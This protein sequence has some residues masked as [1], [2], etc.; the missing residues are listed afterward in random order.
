MNKETVFRIV[1]EGVARG[2]RFAAITNGHDLEHFLPVLGEDRI[3]QIQI[4]L[5]GPKRLHD[6]SRLARNPESSFYKII[7][8]I[9]L[10]PP[11]PAAPPPPPTPPRTEEAGP[12]RRGPAC[13]NALPLHNDAPN[14]HDNVH[15]SG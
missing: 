5:D 10:T 2:F 14:R 9:N 12:P 13:A 3:S 6:R 4:S 7:L 15:V 1:E 11:P 8:N